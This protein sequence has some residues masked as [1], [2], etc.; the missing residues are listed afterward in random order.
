MG[1]S[2]WKSKTFWTNVVALLAMIVQ[3]TVG[4]ALSAEAQIGILAIVNVVLR[5]VTKEPIS[6]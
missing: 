3:S 2:L 6:W 1:K 4:F 5:A